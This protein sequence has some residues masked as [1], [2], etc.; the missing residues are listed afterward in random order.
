MKATTTETEKLIQK[1]LSQKVAS[2]KPLKSL[3]MK[4]VRS[5]KKMGSLKA[6][7][8]LLNQAREDV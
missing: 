6:K 4:P 2:K 7:S 3:S 5:M 8:T 1:T